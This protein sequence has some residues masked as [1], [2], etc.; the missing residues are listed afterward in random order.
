VISNVPT[1]ILMAPLAG[2]NWK[3]LLYAVSAGGCGTIIASLANLLGW[4]IYLREHGPDRQFFHILTYANAAFLVW[5][6][7]GG[8][9]LLG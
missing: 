9:L 5:T 6:A 2:E 1:A 8:W 7:V 4:Q 3:T